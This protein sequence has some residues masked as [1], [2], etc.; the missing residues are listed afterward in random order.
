[1]PRAATALSDLARLGFAELGTARDRLDRLVEATPSLASAV[2]SFAR[3]PDPDEALLHLERLVERSP[4]G[5]ASLLEHGAGERLL[6]LLGSSSGLAEFLVRR[7]AELGLLAEPAPAP[8]S[9]QEYVDD[10][11]A[12]VAG[13]VDEQARVA[14]R[15]KNG[16]APIL[17]PV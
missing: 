4:E 6:R 9:G 15:G 11:T 2:A 17:P 3:S 13:L 12:D 8:L 10:L 5:V 1:M 14:L 16:H 7:P